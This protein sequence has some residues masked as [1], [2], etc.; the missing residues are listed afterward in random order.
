MNGAMRL[1]KIFTVLFSF[2]YRKM[3]C[4]TRLCDGKPPDVQ[5]ICDVCVPRSYS[6]LNFSKVMA[7]KCSLGSSL[8]GDNEAS[9]CC[10]G[11]I[12]NFQVGWL[13]GG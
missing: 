6:F 2:F 8:L 5:S 13:R 1:R 4:R 11:T 7:Q 12:L 10:N 9:I 3:L